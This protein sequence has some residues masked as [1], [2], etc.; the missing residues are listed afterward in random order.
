MG[1]TLHITNGQNLTDYLNELEVDGDFLT[2]HEML[3]EGPT[4]AHIDSEDF[5]TVRKNFLKEYYS[6]ELDEKRFKNEL[7]KLNEVDK[8]SEIVLWFEYDLFCHMNLIAV[9]SLIH[10]REIKLPLYLVCSGRIKG[11]KELKGLSELKSNQLLKLYENKLKLTDL[12]RDLAISLWRTYC[13]KDHNLFKPYITTKSSFEYMGAC[14]KAHLT[15]F[16]DSKSG[17]GVLEKNILKIVKS[18]EIKSRN[19]LLGYIL[20][21]QG[22]Y[23]YGDLQL[24]RKIEELSLF[25]NE[26]KESITLNRIGH[27]AVLGT[28]N[29]ARK[30]KNNISFGGIKRLDYQFDVELNKLVKTSANAD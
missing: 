25:F 10:Q 8:Y 2:W 11:E 26:D 20:N 24:R 1:K 7:K 3:C 23:G 27:E 13:G 28:K 14:L 4:V 6:I 19:H 5:I 17:L 9:M 29:Y 12:D 21:Y 30:I 16:P 22:Y 15:R 18:K